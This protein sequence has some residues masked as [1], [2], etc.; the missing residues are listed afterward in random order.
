MMG[1]RTLMMNWAT[2]GRW[3]VAGA[4][5]AALSSV[6]VLVLGRALGLSFLMPQPPVGAPETV[7]LSPMSPWFIGTVAAVFSL[8]GS[9]VYAWLWHRR[10]D[11]WRIFL[12]L[13]VLV[14]LLSIA[15]T[16]PLST[17]WQTKLGLNII[18]LAAGVST[19]TCLSRV[20]R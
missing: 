8:A 17:D 12:M 7:T 2:F 11:A 3:A 14:L 6:L 10:D 1:E 15:P 5:S 4:L 9:V 19:L 20:P 16:L 13:A 18:H